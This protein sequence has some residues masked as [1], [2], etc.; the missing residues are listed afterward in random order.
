VMVVIL[1]AVGF[2][3]WFAV[4]AG[5][6]IVDQAALL[7]GLVREQGL[8][9]LAWANHH[10][11]AL[12]ARFQQ[13]IQTQALSSVSQLTG[14][15]G[16]VLGGMATLFLIV[17]LGIYLAIDPQPY[18]RGM[19]WLLPRSARPFFE[20]T[21]SDMGHTLRRMLLGRLIGMV[22]EGVTIGV[23]LGIGGVPL[24]SVLGLI[25]GLLAFLPNIGAAISGLLMLLVG[26]SGGTHMALYCIA[27]YVV[28]QGVDGN[29]IVPM[30]AKRTADLAPA[31]VLGMQLVMGALFGILGLALA[32]PLLAMT[33]VLLEKIAARGN[34]P[35][36]P[37]DPAAPAKA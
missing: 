25:A 33:K 23:A 6:Q 10:G 21:L 19:A 9:V 27:V 30:V 12:N 24:S 15:V 2:I 17:V 35:P 7:P 22:V 5:S 8:R 31:L 32:D 29:I 36:G 16:G 4:F 14:V 37:G 18:R 28:V 11:F 20:D 26:L 34:P 13:Q 3:G 1:A